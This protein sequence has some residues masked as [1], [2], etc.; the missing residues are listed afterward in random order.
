[1]SK[2]EIKIK[3]LEFK[4]NDEKKLLD[5]LNIDIKKSEFVGILGPNGCGKTTLMKLILKYFTKSSGDIIISDKKIEEYSQKEMSKLISFVPQK[6]GISLDMTVEDF[7]FMGRTPHI[8]NKWIGFEDK[9][10]K[11]VIDTLEKLNLIDFKERSIFS[12]SG[13]EFQRILLARALVQKTDIIL[14]DEPTSALDLNFSIE[15]MNITEK[16]VKEEKKTVVMVL[17]DL[18]LASMYCDKVIFIKNGEI[19]CSGNPYDLYS[20][21]LFNEVYGFNSDI[22]EKNNY[23]YVVVKKF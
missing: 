23:K 14:L 10:K 16:I 11:I 3:D 7:V 21:E 15:I 12:L 1:M 20:S 2:T 5:C 8:E 18:N 9:D 6:S 22:I 19:K 4:Y 17:H 13:G